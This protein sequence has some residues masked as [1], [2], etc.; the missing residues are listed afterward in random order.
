MAFIQSITGKTEASMRRAHLG[1][2]LASF[3]GAGMVLLVTA[4]VVFG[5]A[6]QRNVIA[7]PELDVRFGRAHLVAYTTHTPDCVR[8]LTSCPPELITVPARDYYVFWVLTPTGQPAPPDERE[9]G[10]RLLTLLLR[11]P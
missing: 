1:A 7:P 2:V 4:T 11:Q 3:L 5:L 9:I 6:I 10:T 8:Y